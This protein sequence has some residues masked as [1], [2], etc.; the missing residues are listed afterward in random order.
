[1]HIYTWILYYFP[2]Y[3][4]LAYITESLYCI[5]KTQTTLSV[6]YTS[7]NS[8]HKNNKQKKES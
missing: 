3:I 6:N 5:R 8:K 4:Y 7:I 2:I 1:M